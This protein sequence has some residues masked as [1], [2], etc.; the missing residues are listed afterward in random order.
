MTTSLVDDPPLI[1]W[2][3]Q[4]ET[5][6]LSSLTSTLKWWRSR[7]PRPDHS[8]PWAWLRAMSALGYLDLDWRADR[9]AC[10]A[11]TLTPLPSGD[12]AF[13][14]AGRRWNGLLKSLES[15]DY[16]YPEVVS[17][18]DIAS[19]PLP[20]SLYLFGGPRVQPH[21]LASRIV[22]ERPEI[23]YSG[24]GAYAVANLL[25][26]LDRDM[27][28]TA[29][30]RFAL[31]LEKWGTADGNPSGEIGWRRHSGPRTPGL[32]RWDDP[33]RTHAWLGDH[34]WRVQREQGIY[35]G[36]RSM[37]RTVLRW[38]RRGASGRLVVSREGPLPA[39]HERALVLASGRL[40][41]PGATG[42]IFDEV[43]LRLAKHVSASLHQQ[44][45]V[46]RDK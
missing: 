45:E 19:L 6:R 10:A 18:P 23:H 20:S 25:P 15:L 31:T 28:P 14:M 16:I 32:Y 5:G 11:P 12:G 38:L 27:E 34:W 39:M 24:C 22:K 35:L 13:F 41:V 4:R 7:E 44:L 29:A 46:A 36:L 8:N 21:H 26:D 3:F 2:L 1:E 40:P 9:W 30:P 33:Y 37:S 42:M 17:L 43:P